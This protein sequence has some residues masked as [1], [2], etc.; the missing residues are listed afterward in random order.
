MSSKDE[1]KKIPRRVWLKGARSVARQINIGWWLDRLIPILI[2]VTLLSATVII[3]LRTF[4]AGQFDKPLWMLSGAGIVI[5]LA[6]I[7]AFFIAGENDSS[8]RKKGLSE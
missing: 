3:C 4:L 2:I 8:G 5:L 1:S 6:T 7:T